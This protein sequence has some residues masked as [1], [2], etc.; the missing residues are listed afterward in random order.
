MLGDILRGQERSPLVLIEDSCDLPGRHVI[1]SVVN[2]LAQRLEKVVLITYEKPS[3]YFRDTLPEDLQQRVEI[4]DCSDDPLGWQRGGSPSIDGEF[5]KIVEGVISPGIKCVGLVIDSLT[6]HILNRPPP[7]TC[8]NL[9][10]VRSAKIKD[11][12]ISQTV[13]LV[14]RD[15]HDDTTVG[16]I[17]HMATTVIKLSPCKSCDF[18]H[19]CCIVHQRASGKVMKVVENFNMD[20][21][22]LLK[23]VCE[24]EP[25]FTMV[26]PDS[27]S[28]ADPAANLPFNLSLTDSEK[29]ARSQVKLPY[30]KDN[31]G[32]K[33]EPQGGGKIFYQPDDA[34]DFDE[35]DPDEDLDI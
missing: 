34:D 12:E 32:A 33:S 15:L 3:R 8:Q 23:E 29:A 7:Y 28:Q 18:Q 35:E 16:L 19:S 1:L 20:D 4:V 9:H 31:E 21:K 17:E 10:A 27:V 22:F 14:H 13:C 30:I 25:T 24:A 6:L 11:C 5:L 2:C 26:M